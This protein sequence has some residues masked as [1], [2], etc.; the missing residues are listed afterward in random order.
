MFPLT[1][2]FR[3]SRLTPHAGRVNHIVLDSD[4]FNEEDDQFALAYAVKAHLKGELVL[5][6]VYAAPFSHPDVRD[7]G[8]GMELSFGEI[9]HILAMLGKDDGSIPAFRGSTRYM[10]GKRLNWD[11]IPRG[12]PQILLEEDGTKAESYTPSPVDSDAARD[13][14][15]RAMS[16]PLDDPLYVCTIGCP[17]NVASALLL[18]PRI[19]EKIVVVFLGGH[20]LDWPDAYEY[21]IRQDIPASRVLLDSGV[22][23]LLMP[24]YNIVRNLTTTVWELEHYIYGRSEIGT[25]LTDIVRRKMDRH[26][27]HIPADEP[28][29]AS[30]VIWDIAAIAAVLRPQYMETKPVPSPRLTDDYRWDTSDASRHSI[31]ILRNIYRDDVFSDLFYHLNG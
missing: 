24:A 20:A 23:L 14:I 25:Y 7:P 22:P 16:R 29:A 5:E 2:E 26:P 1:D 13:L 28:Y 17:T 27:D 21:N 9:H 18:E 15:D 8:E 4:T 12:K 3:L 11:D 31:R 19:A 30:K 6:A 10:H